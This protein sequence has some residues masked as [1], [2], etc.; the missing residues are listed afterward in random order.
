MMNLEHLR[1]PGSSE[2]KTGDALLGVNRSQMETLIELIADE[3]ELSPETI[4]KDRSLFVLNID[5]GFDIVLKTLAWYESVDQQ[6]S[7]WMHPIRYWDLSIFALSQPDTFKDHFFSNG[8][9]FNGNNKI[10]SWQ[11]IKP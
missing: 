4:P 5:T 3:K 9:G 7:L 8:T 6:E 10:V 2:G 1:P 11:R